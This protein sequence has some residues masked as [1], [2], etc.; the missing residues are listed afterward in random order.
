[1]NKRDGGFTLDWMTINGARRFV[2][3]EGGKDIAE[4]PDAPGSCEVERI[5]YARQA[6]HDPVR[7]HEF[8]GCDSGCT[9]VNHGDNPERLT[10]NR[11]KALGVAGWC[12]ET[13]GGARIG[14]DTL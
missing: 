11:R 1:M 10:W 13:T 8:A 4:A 14:L 12:L 5:P 9:V 7:N 2:K 6:K 3:R